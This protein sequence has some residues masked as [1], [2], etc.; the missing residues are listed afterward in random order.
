M[1]S[2]RGR[3]GPVDCVVCADMRA[4]SRRR[5]PTRG[6]MGTFGRHSALLAFAAWQEA[7]SNLLTIRSVM[8]RSSCGCGERPTCRS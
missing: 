7:L 8:G 4:A 3:F 5:E 6:L 1:V 2:V